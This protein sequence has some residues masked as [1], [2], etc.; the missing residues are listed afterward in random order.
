MNEKDFTEL[1]AYFIRRTTGNRKID[2]VIRRNKKL[3]H[4]LHW[5]H[6]ASRCSY[7][8]S[9]EGF[10]Q[11]SFLSV[12]LIAGDRYDARAQI[13]ENSDAKAEE[14]SPGPLASD[15]KWTEW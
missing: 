4:M 10:T 6:D 14:A 3:M 2:F 12:L 5:A 13:K 15:N 8:S 7:T 11:D 1:S 9:L